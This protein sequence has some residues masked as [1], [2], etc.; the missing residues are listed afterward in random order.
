MIPDIIAE[1]IDE[2]VLPCK[3][4]GEHTAEQIYE[5]CYEECKD[6]IEDE[7]EG[8]YHSCGYDT[9]LIYSWMVLKHHKKLFV[10]YVQNA[11]DSWEESK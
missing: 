3:A 1:W 4:D 10:E 5:E 2:D 8:I 6:R 9:T 7:T 11:F